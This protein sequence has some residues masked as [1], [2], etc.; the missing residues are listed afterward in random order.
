MFSVSENGV[1][2]FQSGESREPEVAVFDRKGQL[3]VDAARHDEERT[4]EVA[5]EAGAEDFAREGD[6]YIISTAPNDIHAVQ[7][8]IRVKGIKIEEAELAMVPR[9]TVK[10]EGKDAEALLKLIEAL[11]DLDDVSKV[12]SNVDIDSEMAEAAG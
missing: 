6:Q 11:E 12:F 10:V 5:L 3:Y 9:N 4:L 7:D 1:L 2:I 8:A